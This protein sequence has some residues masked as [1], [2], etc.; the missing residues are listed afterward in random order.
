MA[1]VRHLGLLFG[2][3]DHPR[4][5]LDDR[6]RDFKFLRRRRTLHACICATAAR[7]ACPACSVRRRC[8]HTLLQ[9]LDRMHWKEGMSCIIEEIKGNNDLVREI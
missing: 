5:L 3:L 1:A 4:S 6:K 9:I 7:S 2:K 8:C